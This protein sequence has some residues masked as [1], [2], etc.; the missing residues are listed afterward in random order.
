MCLNFCGVLAG[1][2]FL[3]GF[4]IFM[5]RANPMTYLIQ[6]I[7]SA[8]L[9]NTE[10]VCGAKELLHFDPPSGQTCGDYMSSYI[11][12]AGGN[13]INPSATEGC[14]FCTMK[15]T[16]AFLASVS[17]VYSERWRNFGIFI[18]FIA[19][20]IIGTV[21]CYWLARVPKGNKSKKH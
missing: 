14:K 13:V 16:N 19:I 5:Y 1:P 9:A 4:W 15:S 3:P 17:S 20:N 18:G 12:T 11:S 10:V 6:G 8:G 21:F 7:L 2:D